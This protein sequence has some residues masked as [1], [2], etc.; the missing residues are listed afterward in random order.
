MAQLAASLKRRIGLLI[1][2]IVS[3]LLALGSLW[4]WAI[5]AGLSM[6][7]FDEGSSPV[8]WTIVL[9]VWAYPLFPLLM[10]IGAWA[11]FAFRK[12]RLAAVLT[13]LTFTPPVLFYLFG[14][15]ASLIGP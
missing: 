5:A 10:A 6:M 13:G 12:N 9:T 15:I 8:A 1:W 4:F 11:A 7:A 2:M 14:S 3:Q